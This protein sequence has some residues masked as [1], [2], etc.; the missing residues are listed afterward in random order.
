MCEPG[1]VAGIADTGHLGPLY[2][3]KYYSHLLTQIA[4]E[5]DVSPTHL[6]KPEN[7]TVPSEEQVF[8]DLRKRLNFKRTRWTSPLGDQVD[9]HLQTDLSCDP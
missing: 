9:Y 3:T 6:K 2:F 1:F 4:H 5:E 7:L 8:T